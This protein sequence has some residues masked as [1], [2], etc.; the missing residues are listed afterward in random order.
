M[1]LSTHFAFLHVPKTGG[2]FVTAVLREQLAPGALLPRPSRD[3]HISWEE[4]PAEAAELPVLCFV[5]NPWDW[6]VSW[7]HYLTQTHREDRLK[8]PIFRD[9]FE[10]GRSDFATVVDRVCRGQI[11]HR[12]P[13]VNAL[14][15]EREI[16]LYSARL[17]TILGTGIDDPRLEIGRYERLLEDLEAFLERHRVPLLT[18]TAAKLRSA[19]HL[20]ASARGP[21]RE[22]YDEDLRRLVAERARIVIERFG[23]TF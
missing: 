4:L 17:L 1:L 11:E 9:L 23:Y 16:D 21:Y 12:D 8:K 22:Y 5:R 14:M 19:E 13:R 6:Y 3:S 7:Y 10:G 2:S 20:R 15:A 18:G